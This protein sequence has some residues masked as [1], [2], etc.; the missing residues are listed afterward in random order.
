MIYYWVAGTVPP[1][2][3]TTERDGLTATLGIDG[4]VV[5]GEVVLKMILTFDV[6]GRENSGG[7]SFLRNK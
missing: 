3:G 2:G 4:S 6:S 7:S 5:N 1:R